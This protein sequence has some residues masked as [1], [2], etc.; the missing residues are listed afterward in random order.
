[1]CLSIRN[2]DRMCQAGTD[3]DPAKEL[4]APSHWRSLGSVPR[5]WHRGPELD[6]DAE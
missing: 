6:G 2:D 3:Q 4:V 5:R 1:L